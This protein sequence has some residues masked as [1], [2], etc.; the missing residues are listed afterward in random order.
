[1]SLNLSIGIGGITPRNVGQPI[2]DTWITQNMASYAINAGVGISG[3][4]YPNAQTDAPSA[5]VLMELDNQISGAAELQQVDA[6]YGGYTF[7]EIT[8]L[9][10]SAAFG[11]QS[12]LRIKDDGTA[13]KRLTSSAAIIPATGE[14]TIQMALRIN[15]AIIDIMGSKDDRTNLRMWTATSG[16]AL[17][18]LGRNQTVE[19]I[20]P[21]SNWVGKNILVQCSR[22][23]DNTFRIR[24]TAP[25]TGGWIE[26]TSAA[27]TGN[28]GSPTIIGRCDHDNASNFPADF[29]L[30]S[31][32]VW[33][34][35]VSTENA[36]ILETFGRAQAQVFD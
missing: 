36:A 9:T 12:F 31:L 25:D 18:F 19:A 34:G 26:A 28:I 22:G 21:S 5:G 13:I 8:T 24:A 33:T 6:E 20:H 2:V 15:A 10:D 3:F 1:M 35:A 11:G 23:S 27:A 4:W 7:P 30:R 17:R 32:L 16:T 14:F 29:D